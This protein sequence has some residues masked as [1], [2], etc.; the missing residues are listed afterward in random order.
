MLT[1]IDL[2]SNLTSLYEADFSCSYEFIPTLL[3]SSSAIA[4]I[5]TLSTIYSYVSFSVLLSVALFPSTVTCFKLL[6]LFSL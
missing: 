4:P 1:V 2:P 5:V 3:E 6:L